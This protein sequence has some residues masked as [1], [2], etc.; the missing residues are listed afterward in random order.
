ML[1]VDR[2][3]PHFCYCHQVTEVV[4]GY[5]ANSIAI[6]SDAAHMFSDL[7]SFIVSLAAIHLAMRPASRTMNFGYHRAG[8]VLPQ[9]RYCVTTGR[10]LWHHRA[11][12]VPPQGRYSDTTVVKNVSNLSEKNNH[13]WYCSS[14]IYFVSVRYKNES[15]FVDEY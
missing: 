11:G 6:M 10:V 14:L 9:G 1:R 13:F 12:T 7:T 3:D 8:T 15:L 2:G 4:G 5:L